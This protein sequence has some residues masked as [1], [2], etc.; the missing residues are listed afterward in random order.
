MK[1]ERRHELQHNDL[2]EWI[3]TGYERILPYRN[4][5]LGVILLL[6]VLLV[7]ISFWRSHAA[8][9]SAEAWASL[10]VPALQLDF[11][12]EQMLGVMQKTVQTYKGT[13]P[14]EWAQAFTGDTNLML[15]ANQLLTDKKVGTTYV[16]AALEAYNNEALQSLTSPAREQALFGKARAME[17]LIQNSDQLRDTISAYEEL[18]RSYPQGMYKAIADQQIERLQKG[19]AL[20]F[21]QALAKYSP[22]PKIEA[23]RSELE[24]LKPLGPLPENPEAPLVPVRPDASHAGVMPGIPAP[25]LAPDEPVKPDASKTEPVKLPAVKPDAPKAETPKSTAAAPEAAKKDK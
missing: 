3:V 16:A 24:K 9:Q 19:D 14:A 15:G 20:R 18:N 5:I 2:A 7:G 22:K 23:P 13:A 12:N 10:G 8:A 4:G 17:S 1:S 11:G 21:Y 25:S 6:A